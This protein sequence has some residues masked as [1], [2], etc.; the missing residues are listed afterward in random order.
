M[1]GKQD[2]IRMFGKSNRACA[3]LLANPNADMRSQEYIVAAVAWKGYQQAL[4][5]F[6]LLEV[7]T[8]A[9]P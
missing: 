5:D 6:G 8:S 4:I 2:A 9:K 7:I 3:E 1:I